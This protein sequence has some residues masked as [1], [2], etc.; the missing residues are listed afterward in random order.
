MQDLG[1]NLLVIAEKAAELWEKTASEGWS[2]HTLRDKRGAA[3]WRG[4]AVQQE[5]RPT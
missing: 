1:P 2:H 3:P 5:Q 4:W